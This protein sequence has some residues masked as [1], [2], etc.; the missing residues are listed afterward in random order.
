MNLIRLSE[1]LSIKYAIEPKISLGNLNSSFSYILQ[2]LKDAYANYIT[3]SGLTI[4][5]NAKNEYAVTIIREMN[6]ILSIS[7]SVSDNISVDKMEK[8][9]DAINALLAYIKDIY[10]ERKYRDDIHDQV[11][12]SRKPE[13]DSREVIKSKFQTSLVP[14]NRIL[15]RQADKIKRLL[16]LESPILG[17]EDLSKD[18]KA[19]PK[20]VFDQTSP[21]TLELEELGLTKAVISKMLES[22]ELT[23]KLTTVVNALKRG[24]SPKDLPFLQEEAKRIKKRFGP[25][26]NNSEVF[27]GTERGEEALSPAAEFLKP[28]TMPKPIKKNIDSDWLEDFESRKTKLEEEKD[29]AAKYPTYI[30][31]VPVRDLSVKVNVGDEKKLLDKYNNLS[32]EQFMRLGNK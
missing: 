9:F 2:A 22:Q 6:L 7:N 20:W 29:L 17:I 19:L 28:N 26:S 5:A 25:K 13:L 31:N 27:E 8:I 32:F 18:R 3:N 10:I 21:F 4:L 23:E 15:Y 24:H 30:P 12:T 1:L 11:S 14:L 16:S